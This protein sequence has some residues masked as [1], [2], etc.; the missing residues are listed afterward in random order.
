MGL[1]FMA[2]L[3]PK[4]ED[5]DSFLNSLST[6]LKDFQ[7]IS[8]Y[9]YGSRPGDDN[10]VYG[11][12]DI[13]G[14]F[15]LDGGVVIDR[16]RVLGLSKLLSSS[17]S[18]YPIRTDLNLLDTKSS[19]DGRFLS[20]SKN[21]VEWIKERGIFLVGDNYFDKF[22]GFQF[23]DDELKT[24]SMNLRSVRNSV[25]NSGY[26]ID[27]D[28]PSFELVFEDSLSKVTKAP[29]KFVWLREGKI[30]PSRRKSLEIVR[31]ILPCCD[32]DYFDFLND[33][34]DNP[35]EIDSLLLDPDK[36]LSVLL[37]SMNQLERIVNY[38]IDEFPEVSEREVLD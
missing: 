2:L 3:R 23:K 25:L 30:E 14:G 13:D 18:L 33:L 15:V 36:S 17:K 16:E 31:N 20:Y 26:L 21:Y 22:N 28:Y 7:G 6:G 8:F 5:Y 11:G 4:R 9:I 29:K 35:L 12:S 24:L 19:I 37:N 32:L 1:L 10:F 34:K 27:N 38:Y